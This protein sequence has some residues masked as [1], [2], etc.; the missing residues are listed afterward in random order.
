M[1]HYKLALIAIIYL[2]A[3]LVTACKKTS[4]TPA[5]STLASTIIDSIVGTF[6]ITTTTLVN[7]DDLNGDRLPSKN[8]FAETACNQAS[9][10]LYNDNTM[11]FY[12][13][14]VPIE[15]TIVHD[16]LLLQ[17]ASCGNVVGGSW[18]KILPAKYSLYLNYSANYGAGID[19]TIN[20]T[21][22]PTGKIITTGF[23][24]RMQNWWG[25]IT[26]NYVTCTYTKQ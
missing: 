18:T 1:K 16:M 26:D 11:K 6:K 21:L 14:W 4:G 12:G 17:G 10:V 8:L 19:T 3:V 2:L 13:P 5:T 7:A 25:I 23:K 9:I 20:L 24:L 22:D 15:N